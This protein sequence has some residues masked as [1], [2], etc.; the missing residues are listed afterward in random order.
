[1]AD[2]PWCYPGSRLPLHPGLGHCLI[3]EQ[4]RLRL[5]DELG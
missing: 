3:P 4:R 1:L 2:I 5:K